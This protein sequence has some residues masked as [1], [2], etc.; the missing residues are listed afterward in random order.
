MGEYGFGQYAENQSEK[1]D[2]NDKQGVMI[3][4]GSIGHGCLLKIY[5]SFLGP[6]QA[7]RQTDPLR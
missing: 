1:G 6:I 7:G 2:G 3:T 5:R 4:S